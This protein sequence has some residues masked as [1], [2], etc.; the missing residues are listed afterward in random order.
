MC[1]ISARPGTTL[2]VCEL[3]SLL[4]AQVNMPICIS[5]ATAVKGPSSAISASFCVDQEDE[6]GRLSSFVAGAQNAIFSVYIE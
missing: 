3:T 4:G 5:Y 6:Y 1:S 2:C